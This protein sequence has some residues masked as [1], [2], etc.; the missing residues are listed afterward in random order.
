[1]DDNLSCQDFSK[2]ALEKFQKKWKN[3][4]EKCYKQPQ[5][6]GALSDAQNVAY[7]FS[8]EKIPINCAEYFPKNCEKM[9]DCEIGTDEPYCNCETKQKC[10]RKTC[11]SWPNCQ[12]WFK[13]E[14]CQPAKRYAAVFSDY[15]DKCGGIVYIG[16][17]QEENTSYLQNY[18]KITRQDNSQINIQDITNIPS[19]FGV[20]CINIVID[21]DEKK[22]N[23][24]NHSAKFI[25]ENNIQVSKDY[26]NRIFGT[27]ILSPGINT[28]YE[29]FSPDVNLEYLISHAPSD[30]RQSST[31]YFFAY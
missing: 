30:M 13:K 6:Q 31:H 16:T 17:I 28:L 10:T 20:R 18:F 23:F 21:A 3:I 2:G 19:F 14:N 5:L 4:C 12:N 1:M 15:L 7:L 11:S 22:S 8:Q 29:K 24:E 25:P 27:I 9:F 26:V